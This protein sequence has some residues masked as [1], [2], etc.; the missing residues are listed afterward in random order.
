MLF[1]DAQEQRTA[2]INNMKLTK[3]PNKNITI[4]SAK[5]VSVYFIG[6]E[7]ELNEIKGHIWSKKIIHIS[8]MGGM[9]KSEICKKLFEMYTIEEDVKIKHIGWLEW[10]G[11]LKNTF[12]GGFDI[13]LNIDNT[14]D[15]FKEIKKIYQ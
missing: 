9:G 7:K 11:N 13:A 5:S 14:D 1:G 2:I 6:R 4:R 12:L 8:G 15:R 10:T 3:P